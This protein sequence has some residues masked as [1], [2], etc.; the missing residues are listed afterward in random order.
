MITSGAGSGP[1]GWGSGHSF[2]LWRLYQHYG[3]K[4]LL[5][6][7]YEAAKRWLALLQSHASDGILDNGLSDHESLVPKPRALTGTGF[8]YLNARLFARIARALGRDSDAA[9]A[10]SL[11]ETIK[12]AFNRKFLA[13]RFVRM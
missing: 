5:E 9:E 13:P 3:D 2:L 1:V 6:E 8:Y 12:A 11:A 10:E 7:N 4:R